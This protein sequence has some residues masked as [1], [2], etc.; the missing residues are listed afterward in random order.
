MNYEKDLKKLFGLEF[1]ITILDAVDDGLINK[2]T[3]GDIATKLHSNVGGW[4]KHSAD[5][6]N[7]IFDRRAM[8]QIMSDWYKVTVPQDP[9]KAREEV[10]DIL[11][12]KDVG[13]WR[14]LWRPFLHLSLR[15]LPNRLKHQRGVK[16]RTFLFLML[17]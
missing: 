4:F 6:S 12:E 2:K 16:L 13:L 15:R 8:R 14:Q 5:T 17:Q 3:A 9:V 7:F 10:I 11:R 1:Y